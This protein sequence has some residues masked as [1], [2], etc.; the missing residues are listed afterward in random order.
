MLGTHPDYR[1]RGSASML[2]R[3]G[4][5]LADRDGVVAYVDAS[6]AGAPL[7]QKFGFKDCRDPELSAKGVV[8]MVR[9]AR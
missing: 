5:E 3:W 2:I 6:P 1:R 7:Y 4:C 8:A 9:E